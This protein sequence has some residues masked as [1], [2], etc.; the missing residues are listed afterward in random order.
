MTP[1]TSGW[2]MGLRWMELEFAILEARGEREERG[3]AGGGEF[4]RT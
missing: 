1:G 2:R 4:T 3:R